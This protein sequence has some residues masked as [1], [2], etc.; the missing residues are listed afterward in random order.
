MSLRSNIHSTH[1]TDPVNEIGRSFNSTIQC[2][3]SIKLHTNCV[4]SP[5]HDHLEFDRLLF[6]KVGC[7]S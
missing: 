5:S 4:T 2:R 1:I 3:S 6:Y 7:E